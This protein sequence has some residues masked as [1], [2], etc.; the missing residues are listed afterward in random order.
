MDDS[1]AFGKP[2]RRQA[3]VKRVRLP[4]PPSAGGSRGAG[5]GRVA[6]LVVGGIVVVVVIA[7]A[8]SFFKSSGEQIA[9]DQQTEISQIGAAKDVDAKMTV[10][11]A[12]SAV[13]QLYAEQGSYTAV[14]PA[15]LKRFEPTFTYTTSASTGPNAISVSS[16]ASG[17]GIAVL[18]DSGTCFYARYTTSGTGQGTGTTCTGAAAL[19]S[20]TS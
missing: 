7:G 2:A 16:S 12:A 5:L 14:T 19:T 8:M 18:S 15:A 11:E 17:V 20:A 10:Q 3:S 4:K 1:F 13:Q 9:S 6:L